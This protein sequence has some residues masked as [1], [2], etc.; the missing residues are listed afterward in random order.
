MK[1]ELEQADIQAIAARV[2]DVLLP[3]L[4]ETLR[5][6][7]SQ[8][9]L[10]DIDQAAELIQRSKG[11]IYQLV[12]QARHKLS[13]FPYQKQGRRLRFSKN[14]LLSWDTGCR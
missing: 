5:G 13:D 11:T 1:I 14:K 3:R 4:I 7:D 9:E 6:Q 2:A 10:L 12:D 8:D